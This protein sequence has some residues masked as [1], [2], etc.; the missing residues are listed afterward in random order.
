M[1][2]FLNITFLMFNDLN[3]RPKGRN[4]TRHLGPDKPN[5]YLLNLGRYCNFRYKTQTPGLYS[6][7]FFSGIPYMTKNKKTP[8]NCKRNLHFLLLEYTGQL[9]GESVRCTGLGKDLFWYFRWARFGR[10]GKSV[11]SSL[12]YIIYVYLKTSSLCRTQTRVV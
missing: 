10:S 4:I 3:E 9:S 2:A 8:C 6:K 7:S 11:N 5:S 1:V 12:G